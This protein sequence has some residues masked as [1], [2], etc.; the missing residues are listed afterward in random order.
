MYMF[1]NNGPIKSADFATI[2][3]RSYAKIGVWVWAASNAM[4]L[5]GQII[6]LCGVH[7]DTKLIWAGFSL[8]YQRAY[9]YLRGLIPFGKWHVTAFTMPSENEGRI[10]V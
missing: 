2:I 5:K 6:R 3:G 1:D 4:G 10:G 8:E 9:I 7:K